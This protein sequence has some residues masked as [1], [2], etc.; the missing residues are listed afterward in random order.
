VASDPVLASLIDL[1]NELVGGN[2]V[3][4]SSIEVL[5]INVALAPLSDVLEVAEGK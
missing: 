4:K 1:L 2:E 5:D 3:L